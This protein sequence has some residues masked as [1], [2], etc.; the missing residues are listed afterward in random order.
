LI[1]GSAFTFLMLLVFKENLALKIIT[2]ISKLLP[3][4]LGTKLIRITKTF[5]LGLSVLPSLNKNALI[6]FYSIL[7]W[8]C[9][10]GIMYLG[11]LAFNLEL[12]WEASFAVL[13]IVS[14][15]I[16]LPAPP[17]FIGNFQLFCQGA[18]GLYGVSAAT[19]LSY[20]FVVHFVNL[21]VVL[22]LGLICLPSNMVS[23]KNVMESKDEE[24]TG[25]EI[26]LPNK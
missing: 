14:L 6:L 4:K 5:V 25:P 19:G 20:S 7:Q 2:R 3:E 15:G 23:Y 1:F 13:G 8:F 9:A 24:V 26:A 21:C 11:L 18:L 16:M 12:S 17:G 22:F 10:A